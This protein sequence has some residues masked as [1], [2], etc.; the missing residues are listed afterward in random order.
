MT[1]HIFILIIGIFLINEHIPNNWH[2]LNNDQKP[3]N[4]IHI[5]RKT[6]E[7]AKD[8]IHNLTIPLFLDIPSVR[9]TKQT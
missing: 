5:P 7:S 6:N 3:I 1:T 8:N 2:M 9:T 4:S